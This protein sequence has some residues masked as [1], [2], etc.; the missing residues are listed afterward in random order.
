MWPLS[1][2]IKTAEK[3]PAKPAKPEK[4]VKTGD[5]TNSLPFAGMTLLSGIAIIAI[6]RSKRSSK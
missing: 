2:P 3:A 4:A 5:E 1:A 6:A